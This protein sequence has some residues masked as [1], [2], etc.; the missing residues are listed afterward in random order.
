MTIQILISVFALLSIVLAGRPCGSRYVLKLLK[1]IVISVIRTIILLQKEGNVM[2]IQFIKIVTICS[3]T[4][5]L[6]KI[7]LH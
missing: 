6:T 7:L 2:I 5:T 1:D 4:N 3:L